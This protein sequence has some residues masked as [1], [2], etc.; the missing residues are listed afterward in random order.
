M[1]LHG[2]GLKFWM[3]LT[4]YKPWMIG[5]F[6][7][8]NQAIIR[9]HT[10][11]NKPFFAQRLK[12]FIIKFIAMSVSFLNKFLTIS[13]M[14]FC[15]FFKGTLIGAKTHGPAKVA[16]HMAALF[17]TR[18]RIHPFTHPVHHFIGTVGSKFF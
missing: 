2:S 17:L 1:R 15:A 18:N 12:V 11:E 16:I 4:A 13:I 8:F 5:D 14:G 3:E 6:H 10:A 9:R 7:N